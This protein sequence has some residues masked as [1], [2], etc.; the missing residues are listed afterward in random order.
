MLLRKLRRDLWHYRGQGTAV[1]LV[2]TCGIAS[3]V[4]TR[5][6][7][8]SILLSRDD[9]Y[10]RFRFAD[11]FVS[12][13]RVPNAVFK[14]VT[15]IPGVAAAEARV[16]AEVTLDVPGL[17]EPA[18]GRI[19]SVPDYSPPLLNRL[20]I[21]K[22]RPL[23]PGKR[24]EVLVSEAFASANRLSVGDRVGAV[25]NGRRE[26]LRVAGIALSPEFVY[27]IRG[28]GSILP[29]NHRFGVLWMSR[30]AVASAFD[31]EGGFND[32][33][34]A[35]APG[36]S[37][38][39]VIAALDHLLERYG[40]LGA[41]GRTD[42]VSH[43]FLDN[44]LAEL[45]TEGWIVPGIFFGVAVFLLHVVVTRLVH[46]QRDQIAILKALGFGNLAIGAHFLEF[47]L[48]MTAAGTVLGVVTGVWL[49]AALT[50]MYTLYFRFPVLDYHLGAASVAL[51]MLAMF[52][53]AFLGALGAVRRAV[54]LPPAEAMQPEP[55]PRFRS[56]RLERLGLAHVLRP[57]FRMIVRNL[58]RRP[59]RLALSVL[60]V[61]LAVAVLVLG[62]YFWDMIDD[63]LDVHFRSVERQETT[64]SFTEP[65]SGRAA[66]EIA[67]LPGVLQSESF[68]S[69]P[70]RLWSEHRSKRT[71]LLGLDAQAD[72]R[73]VVDRKR[74]TVVLPAEGIVLSERLAST[75]GVSRGQNLT[76]EVLEGER[77]RRTV[78][79]SRIVDELLGVNAYM[80]VG[81][82]HRLLREEG[83]LSGVYLASDP[84]QSARLYALL[85]RTPAVAGAVLQRSMIQSFQETI[86]QTLGTFTAVLVTLA[87]VIAL[88]IVYNGARIALSERGRELAS[89]R[90]LGFTRREVSTMLLGE[91]ALITALAIP[92]GCALGFGACALISALYQTD[93]M[94]MPL[95]VVPRSYVLSALTV[96]AAAFLSG[97]IVVRRIARMDLVSV[98][99]T[100]E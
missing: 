60:G 23:E 48:A 49:G 46:T 64:V 16:V 42:Q 40:S 91:Q 36:A 89:L 94:R 96:A 82:L 70:V 4:I 58:L 79:V 88:A 85:K 53:A 22:G 66:H 9:Y 83:A 12:A 26:S 72:L 67:R 41:Y 15:A 14:R 68:R 59:F 87:S 76:V 39:T 17:A 34:V 44:E 51:V 80:Q 74:R 63:V 21:R 50:R 93:L 100:R 71:A 77:P 24:D 25:L 84:A 20:V 1:A 75:L 57:E 78:A 10:A 62:R 37:E 73:R 29:D 18:T 32:V 54:S 30:E 97:F 69:V 5:S 55:P 95:V 31:M 13:K 98:L 38:P 3:F 11:V 2:V 86:A 99:K 45:R 52:A 47:V 27:E 7:Y 61:A 28:A 35:L 43:A 8:R 65:R 6:A 19:V 81:A 33:V 56:G 90:V 92:L